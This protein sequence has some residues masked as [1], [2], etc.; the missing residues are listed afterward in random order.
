MNRKAITLFL[1]CFITATT[2]ACHQGPGNDL[3]KNAEKSVLDATQQQTYSQGC[4]DGEKKLS[5]PVS[6]ADERNVVITFTLDENNRIH[7]LD[8]KGGY[9][10]LNHYIRTSLEGKEIH[11]D[12]AI[13]G[14]N[15]V[16]TVKLPASA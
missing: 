1:A 11:A 4:C 12:N 10:F 7:V 15:Y 13:P 9:N 5:I 16:M 3:L 8:V 2:F 14:I 6:I